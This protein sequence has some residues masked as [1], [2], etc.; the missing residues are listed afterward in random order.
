LGKG[1]LA[2][3]AAGFLTAGF[4]VFAGMALRC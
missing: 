2:G 3:L 1:L 4:L